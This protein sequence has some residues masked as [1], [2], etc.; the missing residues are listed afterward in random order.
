[1]L[2]ERP[3]H[4][5][6]RR[7][8]DR[9]R[10]LVVRVVEGRLDVDVLDLVRAERVHR[11]HLREEA[12][13]AAVGAL[14]EDEPAAAG[15]ERAVRARAGLELDHHALA[16]VAD[17]DELLAPRED[18]LHR[19]AARRGRARRRDPRSGSRTWRRSRRRA[20]A[21]STRTCD[22]GICSVC[23]TPA[24]AAYGTCVDVQTVTWSPCHCATTARGSIGT[25]CDRVG[26]VAALDD[27][28]GAGDAPRRRRP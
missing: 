7:G 10:R 16:P 20:A 25:P 18:E 15:D 23:A 22:S 19:A 2:L 9:G 3:A 27:D 6:R 24:R 14:V 17:R 21:R 11:R 1:M 8:A 28:V 12:A 4:L 13:L 5:R 26:D